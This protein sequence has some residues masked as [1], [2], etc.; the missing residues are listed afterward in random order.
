MLKEDASMAIITQNSLFR[1]ENDIENLGDMERLKLVTE[2]LP[3]ESLMCK[4]KKERGKGRDDYP[5]H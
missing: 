4:L 5:V 1:W 3:D 2:H